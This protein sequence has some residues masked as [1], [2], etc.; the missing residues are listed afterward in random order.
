MEHHRVAT[1][2]KNNKKFIV[3]SDVT[4]FPVNTRVKSEDNMWGYGRIIANQVVSR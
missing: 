4:I 1:L 3:Y 2:I